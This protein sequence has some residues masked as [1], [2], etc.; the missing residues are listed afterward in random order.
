[1]AANVRFKFRDDTSSDERRDLITK[2]EDVGADNVEALFPGA[3]EEELATLYRA[4]VGDDRNVA[5]LIRLLERSRE[6]E[7]AEPETDRRLILPVE[8]EGRASRTGPT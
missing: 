7:F 3:P 4:L 1:M 6:V 2:L 8:L 5:K